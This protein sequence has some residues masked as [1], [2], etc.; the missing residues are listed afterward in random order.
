MRRGERSVVLDSIARLA[1]HVHE[2]RPWESTVPQM[3]GG[4]AAPPARRTEMDARLH[5]GGHAKRRG[6]LRALRAPRPG[7]HSREVRSTRREGRGD[8]TACRDWWKRSIV[9]LSPL[10]IGPP[11]VEHR[12][13]GLSKSHLL[14][15]QSFL[16]RARELAARANEVPEV[17]RSRGNR[18]LTGEERA[19]GL[20]EASRSAE[21]CAGHHRFGSRP[22]KTQAFP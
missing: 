20:H 1:R 21:Q 7:N 9:P 19:D 17:R 12:P 18:S 8:C 16:R 10:V 14:L 6:S 2:L 5:G 11:G 15:L 3:T 13:N 22:S 4:A